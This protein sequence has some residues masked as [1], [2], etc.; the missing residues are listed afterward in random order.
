M[1]ENKKKKASHIPVRLNILFFIVFLL[2][3]LLILR[4]GFVQIVHGEDARRELERTEDIIV[5]TNVPRGLIYDRNYNLI[6]GNKAENAIIY[7]RPKKFNQEELLKVARKLADLIEMDTSKVTRGDMV[8]FW[9]LLNPEKAKAKLSDEEWKKYQGQDDESY[10]LQRERVTDEDLATLT[11]KDLQVLA[12]YREFMSGYPLDPQLVKNKD[13]S[14]EEFA[15]VSENLHELPGVDTMIDWDRIYPYGETLQSIL[16]RVRPGLPAESLDYYL[17][18]GYS[19]ND[20][21]GRSYIELQY[22][23]VLRGH[24]EKYKNVTKSGDVLETELI[25]EGERGNDL[26]LTIDIELQKAVEQ[27]I[28]EEMLKTKQKRGTDLLDRAFVTLMDP[29]T[30]EILAMAGKQYRFDEEENKY[31]FDDF[32]AGNFT[33]AYVP[34]SVVKGATVLTGFMTGVNRPGEKL[35]DSP[36]V[37]KDGTRKSSWFGGRGGW[38]DEQAAL[39]RSSNV[40]MYRTA[41]RIGGLRNFQQGGYLSIDK[42]KA[43]REMRYHFSQFGLGTLTGIDLPGEMSGYKGDHMNDEAG[44]ALDFA[45]GQYDTFTPLQLVQYV[46]TIANGGYRIK[47][48]IVKEIRK[49]GDGNSL[50]PIVEEIKPTILNRINA[51][52]YQ[53]ER[54]QSGFWKVF[55]SYNPR[56]TGLVFDQPEYRDLRAAGKTGT[57]ETSDRGQKVWNLTLVAYAPYEKPEVAMSVVVPSA[58]LNRPGIPSNTINLDIGT[59]VLKAYFDLKAERANGNTNDSNE[60]NKQTE[61]TE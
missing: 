33:T 8:D 48:H 49:P 17:S 1:K 26:V 31:V 35:L 58:Y 16:G 44:K 5:K 27:I 20:R 9:I 34:G 12:I 59:R 13:V 52:D 57:A 54:V 23:D 7:T 10:Q 47:P 11:E 55:H 29:Y 42:D 18:R 36:L 24:K 6:V 19:R 43:F 61:E 30:G 41:M 37:F 50:G 56:G 25:S 21:V 60:T 46:S 2:F 22:E 3:S 38:M 14:Q 45:I 32:A 28:E 40:Y 39:A 51:T 15:V 53:I 4:L